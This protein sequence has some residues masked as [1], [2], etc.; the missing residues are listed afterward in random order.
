MFIMINAI[1][2]RKE[3]P[4][5]VQPQPIGSDTTSHN[6]S[7][8]QFEFGSGPSFLND[9][10]IVNNTD[11][12]AVGAINAATD[13][14][15]NAVHWNG[16]KWTLE[17]VPYM[18][19]GLALISPISAVIA[20]ATSDVW[21]V[22]NGVEKWD[23]YS[24]S[25][26]EAVNAVWGPYEME[27]IWMNSDNNIFIVGDSGS[28]AHFSNGIWTRQPSG[29]TINLR[30]VWGTPDGSVV[31]ASGWSNDN[32]QS[33]LL[34]YDGN[35]WKTIWTR[36]G[37]TTPP[38]GDLVTSLW[39]VGN[40]FTSTNYGVYTQDISGADTAKQILAINHFPYRLRGSTENNIAVVGD[41]GMIWHYNGASWKLLND[42]GSGTPLYSVAVSQDLIV[43]V[44]ADFNV[45]DIFPPKAL[46]YFGRRE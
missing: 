18:Y 14:T 1:S 25:N 19:Q 36:Q 10:A 6:F 43:A 22:G 20:L 11:I 7:F 39:G 8:V 35:I 40:L 26:V 17:R 37:T 21:F 27:K 30:D 31:W 23:G 38:Y 5:T 12:W 44:G 46:I 34:K 28:V 9:V 32:S 13:S 33:I 4:V 41:D 16:T 45:T 42:V 29:T 2:C 15:Y 3:S 24:F